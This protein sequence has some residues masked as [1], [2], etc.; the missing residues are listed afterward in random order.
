[1]PAKAD[2]PSRVQPQ[3]VVTQHDALERLAATAEHLRVA[4]RALDADRAGL[5]IE[6]PYV[7]RLSLYQVG[8]W[9]AVHII[10]HNKQMKRLSGGI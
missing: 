6:A 3:G 8:E 4:L 10:R 9:A 2:A 7:G 5:T 1:V